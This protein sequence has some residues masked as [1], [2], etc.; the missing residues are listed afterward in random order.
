KPSLNRHQFGFTLGGPIQHDRTFFFADYEGFR[1]SQKTLTYSTIPTLDQRR[2]ILTV[3]VTDPFTGATYAA[4]AP[5]PMSDFARKLFNDL[6]EANVPG[7]SSSNYQKAVPN[8]SV[9]D[10]ANLK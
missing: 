6:P 8:R 5:I 10:K 9:Y 1:Q 3:L 4:G 2:G 7:A